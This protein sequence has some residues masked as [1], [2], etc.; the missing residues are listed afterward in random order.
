M[1]PP[2]RDFKKIRR[3]ALDLL[4]TGRDL[5]VLVL[6]AEALAATDGPSRSRSRARARPPQP[7]RTLGDNPSGLDL[8]R[9]APA[10]QAA[11]RLNALR[12]LVAQDDMLPE[13]GRMRIVEAAGVGQ[14][15]PARCGPRQWPEQPIR[16][17]DQARAGRRSRSCSR[18][19]RLMRF[20][21]TLAA[22]DAAAARW[23]AI[24]ELLDAR[25]GDVGALPDLGAA[26]RHDR[27]MRA[28]WRRNAATAAPESELPARRH[29]EYAP[30]VSGAAP[31]AGRGRLPAA[32]PARLDS[33]D[34]VLR[35]LELVVDYYRRREPGS[36]VPLLV[37]RA[38]RMVPMTFMEAIGDLAPD[39]LARVQDLL[40]PPY[41][42]NSHTRWARID[43]APRARTVIV[44]WS[45]G[46]RRMVGE[47]SQKFI[48]RNRA[49]RVQIE[50]DV[51]IYGSE[52]KVQLPFVMGV[53][54]DL[55][56]KP[57][58]PPPPMGDR[59][60]LEIDVDNFDDRLK[61]MKPRVAFRCR[62]R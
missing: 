58:E 10:D 54:A 8:G 48:A 50:Y 22:L 37:E 38:R 34:E 5:R 6:L 29:G 9:I 25:I 56:G 3:D 2:Q 27:R 42:I 11:L 12:A 28:I 32:L 35:A 57:A 43:I 23:R 49:P 1:A 36:A 24:D 62:T 19:P 44:K 47:S 31:A 52:K 33:R 59:K 51:E 46:E 14:G 20:R 60:F 55:Y 7:G 53:L 21:R 4:K 13:L 40:G 15:E 30:T 17:R 16:L 39:A 26:D 18:A 45:A 61:A 41:V